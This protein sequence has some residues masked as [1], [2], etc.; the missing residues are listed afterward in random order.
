MVEL[1]E[2]IMVDDVGATVSDGV[3]EVVLPKK[4]PKQKRKVAVR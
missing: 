1:P 3:L 4:A 2:E